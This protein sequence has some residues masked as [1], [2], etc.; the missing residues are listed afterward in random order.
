MKTDHYVLKEKMNKQKQKH[1]VAE[2]ARKLIQ[3]CYVLKGKNKKTKT[4]NHQV[5]GKA[6]KL[7]QCCCYVLKGKK[8]EKTT[9]PSCRK[10]KSIYPVLLCTEGKKQTKKHHQVVGKARKLIQCCCYV[11]KET[12]KQNTKL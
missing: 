8:Q 5:V 11:L 7:I 3:C 10:S 1:Q 4:K 9:T 2:K 12:T 6:R